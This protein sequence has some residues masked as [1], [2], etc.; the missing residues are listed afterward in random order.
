MKK[1]LS[2]ILAVLLVIGILPVSAFAAAKAVFSLNVTEETNDYVLITVNLDSGE[3]EALDFCVKAAGNKIGKCEYAVETDEFL[4][5]IKQI[6]QQNEVGSSLVSATTGIFSGAVTSAYKGGSIAEYKFKKA[7]A[8]KVVQ[9]DFTLTVTTCECKDEEVSTT[10]VWKDISYK[11]TYNANGG[12]ASASSAAAEYGK[13][14]KLPTATRDGYTCLGWAAS[15]S[16]ASA[17]YACGAN[18]TVK[19]EATLYAVW[20]A[21]EFTV[22][23]DGNGGTASQTSK[24]VSYGGTYG[25]LPTATRTGYTFNGWF[26]AASGGTKITAD[27]KFTLNANQTLYAQWSVASFTVTFNANGGT[28][29]QA[30]KSV[31]Y[32]GTY[33]TLPTATRKGY[34]FNGWFTEA[35][36]GTKVTADTKCNLTSN[37][38]LYAQWTAISYKVTFNANGGTVSQ[39]SK[40]V[41]YDGTYGTLPTAARTGYTFNGWF[42]A[43]SGGTKVT[44]DTKYN[45]TSNQTL[46]AQW[47]AVSYKV[48]FDANGGSV[49]PASASAAY[50]GTVALPV[51]TRSGYKCLGWAASASA[52]KA[53]YACG[54]KYTV[55]SNVTLYAVWS[56][57]IEAPVVTASNVSSTGKIKLTWNAVDGAKKY[58][59]YRATSKSGTYK[60][61]WTT[62]KTSYINTS[63]AAGKT[64][65][66]KVCAVGA[67]GSEG[68]M[69]EIVVR[70]CDC[71]KP[72]ITL[73]SVASTGKVK[74]SWKAVEGATGYQVYRSATK[75]GTFSLIKTTTDLSY[76]DTSAAAGEKYYYKVKAIFDG[77][78]S[79]NSAFSSAKYRTTDLAAPVVTVTLTSKGSPKLTWDAVKGA[80]SYK[81]YRSTSKNGT[82]KRIATTTNTSLTNVSANAKTTYYYK[83]IAVH[84]NTAANSAYSTVKSITTK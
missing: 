39:T 80:T 8:E 22:A 37:Q 9:S 55:K 48:T 74:V 15:A 75:N 81:V 84:S 67:D 76:T 82:F 69:S 71:A 2:F 14:V 1:T 83:V 61:V 3:F 77:K 58:N 68:N 20:K 65:Y 13:T 6:K 73:S 31:T 53:D 64:R 49:T 60:L 40:S 41:T 42:T 50:E 47:S 10:T 59:V 51:P 18:Y 44:D 29:S 35:N 30:S 63:I 11:V 57:N 24:K 38:T 62:V 54:A 78:S 79:A 21:N 23:F 19:G 26:T 56:K 36:G 4:G 52:T 34:T 27:T 5:F 28:V 25:T 17:E 12:K 32:G 43:A 46:Y 7:R 66:Y 70:A 33:G 45:L 72:V 16:A